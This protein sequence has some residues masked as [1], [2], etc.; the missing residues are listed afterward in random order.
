MYDTYSDPATHQPFRRSKGPVG[1]VLAG[2][3]RTL[4]VNA[5]LLRLGIA[6]AAFVF[7]P[8]VLLTYLIAWTLVPVDDSLLISER[9]ASAPKVLI[10]IV[11]AI[12]AIQFVFNLV[13]SLP[14]GW[15]VV[16][17]AALYWF[18]IKD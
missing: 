15:M 16:G 13:T 10:G 1:G 18:F 14:F 12:I 17:G 9:P 5:N 3:G 7:G 2:L 8:F 4:G 6:A 11:A